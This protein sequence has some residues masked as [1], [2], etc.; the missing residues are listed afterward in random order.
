[1]HAPIWRCRSCG[2]LFQWPRPDEATL[3]A[4]YAAVEDPLYLAEKEN[5]RLTFRR[6]LAHLGPPAGRRLLD[7]GA[8]CGLFVGVAQEAGFR[9]EG[10]ELSRW[11]VAQARAQGLVVRNESIEEH[12]RSGTRYD[13]ITMWDV[14]EHLSHPRRDLAACLGLLRR[15]GQLHLSTIDARSF[16]ARG[17]GR[18]WPW[19]MEMHLIY[20]DRKTL[21]AL[22]EQTGFRVLS[23]R[24]YTHTVSVDYL[25]RKVGASFP[26]F[27]L[28][29]GALRRL[30]PPALPIPVNLGDNMV[31]TA[32]R[33]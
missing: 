3:L 12:A 24:L 17:L 21:P 9:A 13:L 18:R 20:F 33:P 11:A 23:R 22:L 31:V 14:V 10:I 7:V 28:P 30:M 8:Y 25:L 2:L 15:G 4:R 1:V 29:C 27:A 32:E 26:P 19:L 5:R 16:L 6:A